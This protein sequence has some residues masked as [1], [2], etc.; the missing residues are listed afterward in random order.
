MGGVNPY[1]DK[2]A[3]ERPKKKFRVTFLIEETG[4]RKIFEADP[5]DI[6]YGRTGLEGSILDISEGAGL[7]I[8]QGLFLSAIL[9]SK[10]SGSH[11]C[12][13]MLLP[14][15]EAQALLPKF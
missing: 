7:E 1:I 3:T 2:P 15:P 14:K 12:H 8:D 4:E 11:L 10:Q 9:G 5:T 13:A 6:P